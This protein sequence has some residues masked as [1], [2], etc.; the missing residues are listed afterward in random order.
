MHHSIVE[1]D[2]FTFLFVLFVHHSWTIHFVRFFNPVLILL[3]L[4]IIIYSFFVSFLTKQL[5]SEIVHSIKFRIS[6]KKTIV[7]PSFE[8]KKNH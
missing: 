1:M 5:L 7:F 2:T 4:N 8:V 3:P 6:I